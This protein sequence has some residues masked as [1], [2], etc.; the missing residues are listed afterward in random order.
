MYF[1][2]HPLVSFTTMAILVL[3]FTS[4]EI[5]NANPSIQSQGGNIVM[6]AD[7]INF[8]L[9][10]AT[11]FQASDVATHSWTEAELAQKASVESVKA[12]NSSLLSAN[13]SIQALNTRVSSLVLQQGDVGPTGAIGAQGP[14]GFAGA[15]GPTGAPG[16]AGP[17]G[18]QGPAGPLGP[19]G[20][21]GAAGV[22][23]SSGPIGP[24]GIQGIVGAIG[25]TGPTG[26]VGPTGATGV[27]GPVGSL[28]PT[29]QT[30]P[31]GI[32]G[33]NASVTAQDVLARILAL[34]PL[35]GSSLSGWT[36]S[37]GTNSSAD[38]FALA[39]RIACEGRAGTWTDG[40]GCSEYV[41]L[42]GYG[43]SW[44]AAS[45]ACSAGRHFCTMS[46]MFFAGFASLH[47]QGLR[48]AASSAAYIWLT[49]HGDSLGQNQFYYPWGNGEFTCTSTSAPMLALSVLNC[50]LCAAFGCYDKSYP[51][52][53]VPCCLTA[54]GPSPRINLPTTPLGLSAAYLNG[55]TALGGTDSVTDLRALMDRVRC[56]ARAGTW[57]DDIG[58]VEFVTLACPGCSFTTA[59]TSCPTGR[60]LCTILD[61]YYG[62]FRSA[63]EQGLRATSVRYY[64]WLAGHGNSGSMYYPWGQGLFSCA[65]GTA[66]MYMLRTNGPGE[67]LNGAMGC[68]SQTYT[69]SQAVCCVN[70]DGNNPLAISAW[71]AF[72]VTNRDHLSKFPPGVP[73]NA[74]SVNGRTSGTS[75]NPA[76]DIKAKI[77]SVA[78]VTRSGRWQSN[79]CQEYV[80]LACPG[81]TWT[82]AKTSCPA[83]RHLCTVLDLYYGGFNSIMTQGL[84][85]SNSTTDI[86]YIWAQGYQGDNQIFYN[87]ANANGPNQCASTAA[88][89]YS[90]KADEYDQ[91]AAMGCYPQANTGVA[92]AACCLNL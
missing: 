27:A 6:S 85:S 35:D 23:G 63:D 56:E 61:M 92:Q 39:D 60:H 51:A 68:Y 64:M 70:N 84:R 54:G 90:I 7:N 52:A 4:S 12:L 81:C 57:V 58:C 2:H 38:L 34:P 30:G 73:I 25:S 29:G 76:T 77:D 72:T 67:V 66:P 50:P 42:A 3:F 14:T 59:T 33:T 37:G 86:A 28:G 79:A 36:L 31:A 87:W 41:I 11:S 20:L 49:G 17:Q 74:A 21:P 82:A 9:S 24:Q 16:A 45:G 80:T 43:L 53:H 83:G 75:S 22:Q 65:T 15:L 40:V 8:S 88:P 62:G 19:T 13:N 47:Q 69:D 5:V 89:M 26:G 46:E 32:P 78:C 91:Q 10:N 55:F 18:S 1:V 44:T 71:R 48:T